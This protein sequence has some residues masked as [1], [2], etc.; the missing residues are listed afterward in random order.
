[1]R[2][3][4]SV[5]LAL[6]CLLWAA[7]QPAAAIGP[8]DN[9]GR[10]NLTDLH[11]L[12]VVHHSGKPM[13]STYRPFLGKVS[14]MFQQ[15]FAFK[16]AAYK[17]A[18]IRED[19][20]V[21]D[22]ENDGVTHSEGQGYG[23][24]L[25]L[26]ADD[27]A[28]FASIWN[29]TRRNM[30]RPDGLFSWRWDPNVRPH[31]TD[32]NNATD[33]DILI[34]TALALASMRWDVAK[35]WKQAAQIAATVRETLVVH[36]NETALLLPA[37]YGFHRDDVPI[38][39][40]R[41][42]GIPQKQGPVFNLSYWIF[43]AFPIL[44]RVDPNPTWRE[45][46]ASGLALIASAQGGPTEWSVLSVDGRALPAPGRPRTFGYNAVRIPLYLLLGG[47]NVPELSRHL[48]GVWGAPAADVPFTFAYGDGKRLDYMNASGYRLVHALMHC[49]HAGSPIDMA[50]LHQG[51]DAYYSSSLYLLAI[52]VL[53]THHPEC[54]P[55]PSANWP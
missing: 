17:R 21:V 31:V 50:L 19:G 48:G 42:L 33:G 26:E 37:V 47:Y 9:A 20:R 54:A 27:R 22:R 14:P 6:C 13:A 51:P 28:T 10:A 7:V 23:M 15:W 2:P 11:A 43:F 45:L 4:L 49:V 46:E 12:A 36:H 3:C 34:A 55:P 53:Y 41:M 18:F 24:L 52:N 16:F 30:R 38:Q 29:F 40:A 35:Y 1:M 5:L 8:L 44:D 32:P 25:A 39:F